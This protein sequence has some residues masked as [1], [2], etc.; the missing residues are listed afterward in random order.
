MNDVSTVAGLILAGGRASRFE[1]GGK[2]E[3]LLAGKALLDHVIARAAPQ[4]RIL[5]I[6]RAFMRGENRGLPVVEDSRQGLGP[7]AGLHAGLSW[8]ASLSPSVTHLATFPCDAPL[9]PADLVERLCAA[10]SKS[11]GRA[12]IPRCGGRLHPALAL[13]PVSVREIALR[14]LSSGDRSLRNFA[15]DVGA[16]AVDFENADAFFNVNTLDDLAAAEA[17]LATGNRLG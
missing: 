7:L 13:W 9:I 10:I 16:T 15:A 1:G 4:V 12:A 5:A 17:A 8:S 3:A 2:E 14:R 11:P 6:S